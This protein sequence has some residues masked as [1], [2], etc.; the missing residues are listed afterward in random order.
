M[1]ERDQGRRCAKC[2]R[3]V[4]MSTLSPLRYPEGVKWV[5]PSCYQGEVRERPLDKLV[6]RRGNRGKPLI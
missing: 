1:K 6:R 5:C 2:G 4:R 3:M